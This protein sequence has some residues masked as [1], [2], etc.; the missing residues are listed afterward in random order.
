[1]VDY[2]KQPKKQIEHQ[3]MTSKKV[4]LVLYFNSFLIMLWKAKLISFMFTLK[5]ERIG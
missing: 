3:S 4:L 5:K 2:E 1:M